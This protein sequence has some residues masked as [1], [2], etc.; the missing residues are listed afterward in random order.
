MSAKLAAYQN[1]LLAFNLKVISQRGDNFI[2]RIGYESIFQKYWRKCAVNVNIVLHAC[3]PI[4]RF[5]CH[6]LLVK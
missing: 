2:I 1:H 4:N 5:C 3:A 6:V